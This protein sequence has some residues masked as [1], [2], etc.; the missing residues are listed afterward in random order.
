MRRTIAITFALFAATAVCSAAHFVHAAEFTDT[1]YEEHIAEL[2][3]KLPDKG[4]TIVIEKPFV[5]IGDEAPHAVRQRA[6]STIRWAVN[7]LKKDYFS[8]NPD[9]IINIWLFKDKESYETNVER[10]FEKKPTTPFGYYSPRHGVLVMN[11]STG[12]GTL[13]HEIVHP[14]MASNFKGCPSWLN[15]GLA[16]LYEHCGQ[17]DGKI[18][19]YTNWRLKGLQKALAD[20]KTKLPAFADLCS[21]TTREFYAD[22]TAPTTP[23]P[24]TSATTSSSA[25]SSASITTPSVATPPTTPP[26]TK[27][28]SPPSARPTWKNFKKCGKAMSPGSR[29]HN[30]HRGIYEQDED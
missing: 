24:A 15:E 22:K 21:T 10:L 27:P 7:L 12:S 29:C 6:R 23:K 17:Y 18:Y 2:R 14:F 9:R 5:V 30:S 4:F 8:D 1:Q 19:G 11:I 13:V 28:S 20:E 25:A 3:G 26:A 16:S